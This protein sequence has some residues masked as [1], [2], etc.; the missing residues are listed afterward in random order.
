VI[1]RNHDRLVKLYLANCNADEELEIFKDYVLTHLE[2]V[3]RAANI[4]SIDNP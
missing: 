4:F 1:K 2:E 3:L